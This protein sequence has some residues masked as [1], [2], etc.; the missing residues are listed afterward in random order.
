MVEILVVH[1]VLMFFFILGDP[2]AVSW[3]D[4]LRSL[5]LIEP[6]GGQHLSRRFHNFLI[7]FVASDPGCP[8]EVVGLRFTYGPQLLSLS[9]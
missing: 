2:G 9:K 6:I 4:S 7:F 5:P 3:V 8:L 1:V